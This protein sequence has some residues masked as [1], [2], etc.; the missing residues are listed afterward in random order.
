[1]IYVTWQP[2]IA[3]SG[4]YFLTK[5]DSNGLDLTIDQIMN[6]AHEIEGLEES[7]Y[8]LCSILRVSSDAEVIY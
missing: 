2:E 8:D 3:E 4:D 7:P 6:L 5:I 1:M